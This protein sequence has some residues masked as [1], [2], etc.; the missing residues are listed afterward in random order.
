MLFFSVFFRDKIIFAFLTEGKYDT[1]MYFLR[2]III[3]SPKLRL[4]FRQNNMIFSE[5]RKIIFQCSFFCKDDSLRAFR[6]IKYDSS[7]YIYLTVFY[8]ELKKLSSKWIS[9][10]SYIS[11]ILYIHIYI[12][13]YIYVKLVRSDSW[14]LTDVRWA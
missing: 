5:T 2:K 3:N 9:Y 12:Y 6:K 1:F 11:Y 4:Y 8:I 14:H 13:I 7:W 10:V